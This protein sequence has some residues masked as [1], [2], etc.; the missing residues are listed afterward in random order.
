MQLEITN[1]PKDKF[2]KVQ[3]EILKVLISNGFESIDTIT[4]EDALSREWTG[5]ELEI[6]KDKRNVPALVSSSA[7]G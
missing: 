4:L 5:Y 6:E 2:Q 3:S 1:I 7:C